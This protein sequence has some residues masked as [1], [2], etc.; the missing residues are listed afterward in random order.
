MPT[1]KKRSAA[2]IAALHLPGLPTTKARII[3]RA[4]SEGWSFEEVTGRGGVRKMYELPERYLVGASHVPLSAAV[5]G[6]IA[7]GHKVDPVRLTWAVKAL[8]EFVR[9]TGAEIDPE[10]KGAIIAVL[11]DYLERGAGELELSNLLHIVR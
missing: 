3:E 11:Y 8:E 7:G 9:E 1:I 10:R 2:E 6:T 5:A 4:A